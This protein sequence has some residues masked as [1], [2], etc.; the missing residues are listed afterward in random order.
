[1][2]VKPESLYLIHN[3]KMEDF[4]VKSAKLINKDENDYLE[5]LVSC[6]DEPITININDFADVYGYK[7]SDDMLNEILNFH[8]SN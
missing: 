4:Y 3:T 5:L 7:I 2:K 1:M 8:K 6:Q